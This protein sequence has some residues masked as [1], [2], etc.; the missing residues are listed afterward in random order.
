M[1]EAAQRQAQPTRASAVGWSDLLEQWYTKQKKP[2]LQPYRQW[3][4]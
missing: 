2:I 3:P 1:P 4:R